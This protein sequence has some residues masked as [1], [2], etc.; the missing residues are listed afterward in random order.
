[1]FGL[2]K[3][4]FL[5]LTVRAKMWTCLTPSSMGQSGLVPLDLEELSELQLV[6]TSGLHLE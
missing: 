4:S 1:V 2:V 5:I 3:R 6:A